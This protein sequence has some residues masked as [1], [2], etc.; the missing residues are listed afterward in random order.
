M[1][2]TAALSNSEL[3]GEQS[4][5]SY[6]GS[7]FEGEMTMGG[8]NESGDSWGRTREGMTVSSP[9]EFLRTTRS[10]SRIE[11]RCEMRSAF[12]REL[13][14]HELRRES[15]HELCRDD[16]RDVG[17]VTVRNSFLE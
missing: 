12:R 2:D 14:A 3:E 4:S 5:T 16:G 8:M 6:S 1:E 11:L 10:E 13:T 17:D 9:A 15:W 7:R